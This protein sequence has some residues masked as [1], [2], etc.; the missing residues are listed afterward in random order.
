MK[1]SEEILWKME[2]TVI[3]IVISALGMVLKGLEL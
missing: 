2:M 1:T 3:P